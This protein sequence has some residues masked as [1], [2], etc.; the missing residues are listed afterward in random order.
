MLRDGNGR[1]TSCIAAWSICGRHSL[2]HRPNAT[3]FM[4]SHQATPGLDA[5]RSFAS[6]VVQ[7]NCVTQGIGA[8]PSR[9]ERRRWGIPME[10]EA[11]R[12]RSTLSHKARTAWPSTMRSVSAG[13]VI[14]GT[15]TRHCA[16]SRARC[17]KTSRAASNCASTCW[18]SR[19][20]R[21]PGCSRACLAMSSIQRMK[22]SASD[23]ER[24]GSSPQ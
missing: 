3:R 5:A 11:W 21:Q 22:Y 4:S 23:A 9:T 16:G 24:I 20:E 13:L 7:R 10:T 15:A 12:C 19:S 2:G 14:F 17:T 8:N 1:S 18:R 6:S